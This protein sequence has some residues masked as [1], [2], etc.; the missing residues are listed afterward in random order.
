VGEG[1]VNINRRT[2]LVASAL[3]LSGGWVLFDFLGNAAGYYSQISPQPA[4]L[5]SVALGPAKSP[6]EAAN[7]RT[8][9]N[10]L[11]TISLV[12]LT[13]TVERPLFNQSRAPK[14]KAEPQVAVQEEPP[15]ESA[16]D[17]T[18]LGIVVGK[19]D[20]TVLLK[21]NK[22]NEI[23]H[24]KLG[25]SFSDWK[26]T[27]IGPRSVVIKK[28]DLAFSLALFDRPTEA[29]QPGADGGDGQSDPGVDQSDDEGTDQ[30]EAV[31]RLEQRPQPMPRQ[32]RPI[33]QEPE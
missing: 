1:L 4:Q 21:W 24:L 6:V 16:E 29:T 17:F 7:E 11:N 3:V 14:P 10:P 26:V 32:R 9:I 30:S 19:N 28:N 23:Y 13:Q 27:E 5:K 31:S 33:Q 18:L 2:I 20:K 12:S 15:Q 25:Q 22:Q 8:S